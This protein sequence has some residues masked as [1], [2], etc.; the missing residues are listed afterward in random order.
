MNYL[1]INISYFAEIA[2]ICI[3]NRKA[4]DNAWG[5]VSSYIRLL[6]NYKTHAYEKDFIDYDEPEPDAIEGTKI[7]DGAANGN[8]TTIDGK[9]AGSWKTL[10]N[11]EIYI[12]GGRKYI[13][14]K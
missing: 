14:N 6:I 12:C 3:P 7:A 1:L 8:A 11:G 10:R 13:K 4:F 2:Y 9:L 5:C